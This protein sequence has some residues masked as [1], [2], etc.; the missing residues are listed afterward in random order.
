MQTGV[1]KTRADLMMYL[2]AR[3]IA[4]T[5]GPVGSWSLKNDLDSCGVECSTA[6]I[7][8][9]LKLL[10]SKDYTQQRSNQG[11][12]LTPAGRAW[13]DRQ[14]NRVTRAK[15]RDDVSRTMHVNE[16]T[17][18]V[19]LVRM[20]KLIEVEAARLAAQNADEED[21]K[22]LEETLELHHQYVRENED[23]V[24]PAL[25]FHLAVTRAGHNK[26]ML[27]VLSLLALE[28]KQI[29]ATIE[30]LRTREMGSVY[31]VEHDQIAKAIREHDSERAAKLMED[32][33]QAILHA[34]ENQAAEFD[35]NGEGL[36]LWNQ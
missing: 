10:D 25:D 24:D 8:R 14:E 15:I 32:H 22:R 16:Y 1:F 13:L 5:D 35:E 12:V 31:V 9:Y 27:A 23:P 6:T 18:M 26:F 20:R 34:V 7:G 4:Q 19:D 29:E 28:E 3:S 33:M 11:R 2:I 21:I 30:E 36:L 17:E